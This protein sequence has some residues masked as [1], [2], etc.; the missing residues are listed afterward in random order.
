MA[1]FAQ[2]E[3]G[4]FFVY[5]T[6]RGDW[7]PA[8][9]VDTELEAQAGLN[10]LTQGAAF[11]SGGLSNIGTPGLGQ[12]V[13]T[14]SP[15]LINAS[16]ALGAVTGIGALGV[17]GAKAGARAVAGS[18]S[19]RM[20]K[21]VVNNVRAATA[22]QPPGGAMPDNGN[23]R[24]LEQIGDGVEEFGFGGD[25]AGAAA[26]G[27][28]FEFL[29][30]Q[31]ALK[32]TLEG[33]DEFIGLQR[34]M[35]ADQLKLLASGRADDLGFKWLPGQQQGNLAIGDIMS[36]SPFMND[37]LD[38]VIRSNAD[39]LGRRVNKVL[40]L[41]DA[42]EFGRNTLGRGDEVLG[43]RFEQVAE[44]LPEVT[45]RGDTANVVDDVLTPLEAKAYG[46]GAV[47]EGAER[48][49]RA[50]G[51]DLMDLRKKLVDESTRRSARE[52]QDKVVRATQE[53]IDEIDSLIEKSLEAAG[54][55]ETLALWKDTKLRW[56]VRRA[57]ENSVGTEGDVSL[58]KLSANLE[59]EF[60]KE[61]KGR[62]LQPEDFGNEDVRDLLDYTRLART[63]ASNLGDS[64][65]ASRTAFESMVTKPFG[66]AKQRVA[67]KF[68]SDVLLN[69]S[70]RSG[71]G[72]DI[73]FNPGEIVE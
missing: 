9:S 33:L 42:E 39:N 44:N 25:S 41:D 48:E 19:R 14:R 2:D 71:P 31:P 65:T 8:S 13:D 3:E 40:G 10:A 12:A 60:K 28:F 47:E 55:T 50:G 38:P 59:R 49:L 26:Q 32:G 35:S 63:F 57:V 34:P 30:N 58:K 17:M 15:Q 27:G 22:V 70:P 4:N 56:R 37:A 21:R 61:Y 5:D 54:D 51:R 20:S 69:P 64:G 46:L 72:N 43:G 53:A 24:L 6:N 67:S 1:E 18:Q 73:G 11:M 62:L 29:K 52:G 66:Y 16:D 23:L 68:I 45:I 36:K 7:R